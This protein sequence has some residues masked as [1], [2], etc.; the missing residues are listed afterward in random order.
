MGTLNWDIY[1]NSGQDGGFTRSIGDNVLKIQISNAEDA[2]YQNA[3]VTLFKEPSSL[4]IND[5][6]DI[7]IDD[8][9]NGYSHEFNGY[10]SRKETVPRGVNELH[11]QC[12]GNTYNLWRYYC[13]STSIY[14]SQTTGYIAHDIVNNFVSGVD[15]SLIPID[16]GNLVEYIDLSEWVV[17]D[18]L[19]RLTD[20]DGYHFYVDAQNRL[21]YYKKESNTQFTVNEDDIVN[22]NHIEEAD[23]DLINIALVLGSIQY[24]YHPFY[25]VGSRTYNMN[26]TDKWIAQRFWVDNRLSDRRLSTVNFYAD[27]ATGEN[28]PNW[29][30]GS[31]YSEDSDSHKVGSLMTGMDELNW[32]GSSIPNPPDWSTYSKPENGYAISSNLSKVYNYFLILHSDSV[33]SSKWW[34]P[35]FQL[36]TCCRCNFDA[37]DG[38]LTC[39]KYGYPKTLPWT[40]DRWNNFKFPYYNWD[41][42]NGVMN[43]RIASNT[44]IPSQRTPI[45]SGYLDKIFKL[46][47]LDSM[48]STNVFI[49]ADIRFD[50]VSGNFKTHDMLVPYL[51]PTYY[52]TGGIF[53]GFGKGDD[54]PTAYDRG[55]WA[56][57]ELGFEFVA[58]GIGTAMVFPLHRTSD[59]QTRG[60]LYNLS[61]G[62]TYQIECK[63]INH[64][65]NVY[66]NLYPHRPF[67]FW[68]D[69]HRIYVLSSSIRSF[70]NNIARYFNFMT[71][72]GSYRNDSPF[73]SQILS[74]CVDNIRVGY[75]YE[76]KDKFLDEPGFQDNDWDSFGSNP[77][78]IDFGYCNYDYAGDRI[79]WCFYERDYDTNLSCYGREWWYFPKSKTFKAEDGAW[80]EVDLTLNMFNSGSQPAESG[81]LST[82]K[83][84][85]VFAMCHSEATRG[86]GFGFSTKTSGSQY[87]KYT[88]PKIAICDTQ[89]STIQ[90]MNIATTIPSAGRFLIRCELSG[91]KTYL[92]M[93]SGAGQGMKLI[94]SATVNSLSQCGE[95]YLRTYDRF[96]LFYEDGRASPDNTAFDVCKVSG[97]IHSLRVGN[98]FT[99][100]YSCLS[101]DGG[102]SWDI[103]PYTFSTG[104]GWNEHQLRSEYV[105][106]ESIAQYGRH[107]TR[108]TE[109]LL[110]KQEDVDNYAKTL[111]EQFS[112]LKYKGNITIDGRTDI[113]IDKRI[114]LD[115]INMGISS[116]VDINSYV[117]TIDGNGFTTSIQFGPEPYNLASKVAKLEGEVYS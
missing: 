114:T 50:Y 32:F 42:T 23:D 40:Q 25:D 65:E 94:S 67:E 26:N 60:D 48:I 11:L 59:Y 4:S 116:T 101:T 75:E 89:T 17:G 73:S 16:S 97:G 51:S 81:K 54:M 63:L 85:I 95:G 103:V 106:N 10:V 22:I 86:F 80:F 52:K 62:Q 77:T 47:Q 108:Y 78:G 45:F 49:K 110:T 3:M 109:S 43:F 105:S 66:G 46:Q 15:A 83:P 112:G 30:Q 74:G 111:I 21:G 36:A 56:W 19:K 7:Y 31:I 72:W 99:G 58:S 35:Y 38:G 27:R 82:D 9:V 104:F 69:N 18:A 5:D 100:D 96:A 14:S 90:S 28:M 92:F 70:D 57:D 68:I 44:S 34:K 84:G 71:Y 37:N 117:H 8:G 64:S 113:D 91:N 1:F 13:S 88:I 79:N 115:L 6:V 33:T 41:S 39:G 2:D 20:F 107:L 53:L 29:M 102:T 24:E 98:K 93:D 87:N 12:I 76:I 55:Y 61:T